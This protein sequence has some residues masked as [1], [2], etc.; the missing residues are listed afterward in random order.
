MNRIITLILLLFVASFTVNNASAGSEENLQ[1]TFNVEEMTC[2][3]CPITVRKAME[4]VDGVKEVM[5][6]FESKTATVIFD[7]TL[8]DAEQIAASSSSVGF[9]ATLI[10]KYAQ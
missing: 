7:P 6:D 8:T 5:V 3:T 2:A 4:S 1:A 9:P 10:E